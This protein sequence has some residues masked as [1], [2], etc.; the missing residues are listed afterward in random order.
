MLC[1]ARV[2]AG[3]RRRGVAAAELAIL[4]PFLALLFVAAVDFGRIFYYYV[5]I[6]NCARGGAIYAS[7]DAS[8]TTDTTGITNAAL[9]DSS[10]LSPNPSVSS[11]TGNDS[12]GNAYVKVTVTY[13][14]QT[15]SN[16]PLPGTP[17]SIT[18]T[19]SVQMRVAPP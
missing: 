10:N 8:H 12:A 6:T 5:T 11:T 19:R 2:S 18:L 17:N 4:L 15:I 9:A 3:R 14:F 13:T 7:S 16:F 1:R